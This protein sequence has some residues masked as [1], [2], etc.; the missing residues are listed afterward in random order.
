MAQAYYGL[1]HADRDNDPRTEKTSRLKQIVFVL[2][3]V[4]VPVVCTHLVRQ[5][6]G[7]LFLY[8]CCSGASFTHSFLLWPGAF[9][10]TG[11]ACGMAGEN[12][13][14]VLYSGTGGLNFLPFASKAVK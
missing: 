13:C 6:V 1:A 4:L 8:A 2:V 9:G 10:Y 5:L 12:D 11:L 7:S 14:G 3:V